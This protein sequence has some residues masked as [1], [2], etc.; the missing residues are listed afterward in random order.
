MLKTLN[1]TPL[2][3]CSSHTIG[4]LLRGKSA[5]SHFIGKEMD[6]QNRNQNE[7]KMLGTL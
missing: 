3:T 6:A 5:S 7:T 1:I 4:P 2:K